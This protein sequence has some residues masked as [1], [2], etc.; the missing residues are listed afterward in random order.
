MNAGGLAVSA[1]RR[2]LV[3]VALTLVTT[4]TAGAA[5]VS[6]LQLDGVINPVA[7]RLVGLAIERARAEGATALVIQLDTPGGLE[8]SMRSIVRDMLNAPLPVIVYV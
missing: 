4:T 3:A 5:T 7:V 2:L 1:G 8:R 6:T